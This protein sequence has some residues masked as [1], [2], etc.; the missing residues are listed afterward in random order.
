MCVESRPIEVDFRKR[1]K[2]NWN[3][4]KEGCNTFRRSSTESASK[5]FLL[6]LVLVLVLVLVGKRV[7]LSKTKILT[8]SPWDHQTSEEESSS[9]PCRV[10][11]NRIYPSNSERWL[12][13]C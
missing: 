8:R 5:P 6:K 9:P 3:A 11:I 10:T 1:R 2:R 13:I 4:F 12:Q 7:K